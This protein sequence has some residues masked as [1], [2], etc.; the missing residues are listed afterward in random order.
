MAET[1]T[2]PRVV[3]AV[4]DY[5]PWRGG[6]TNLARN[7]ALGLRDRGWAVEI[8]TQRVDAHWPVLE[9]ID[10]V[11]VR[12]LPPSA[13]DGRSMRRY[14]FANLRSLRSARHAT[15]VVV[16]VM[17]PDLATGAV[18]AG[19][20]RRTVMVWAGAGD[21]HDALHRDHPS[22]AGRTVRVVRRAILRRAHHVALTRAID[23]EV[24]NVGVAGSTEVIPT[25]IDPERFRP[26]AEIE[27]RQRRVALGV[28]DAFVVVFSG[29]LRALKR[30]DQLVR[31]VPIVRDAHVPVRL[32]VLGEGRE[33]L[34]DTTGTLHALAHELGVAD[35]VTFTGAV[36][37]VE[38]YLAIADAFVLPSEREGLSNSLLEAMACGVACVA[39][40]SAGG[41]QILDDDCG[42][43]PPD[44][45]PEQLAAALVGLAADP[46][47][48]ARLAANARGRAGEAARDAVVDRYDRL[49]RG[50][51]GVSADR[52]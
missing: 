47:R 16:A 21:A 1:R 11:L 2:Q 35:A 24:R 13:R 9:R 42:V 32:F 34:V 18:V 40:A 50:L 25:P 36:D 49:L 37:E 3:V 27:R 44:N 38:D 33:D 12:R 45:S 29:H 28:D 15:D 23:D 31:A 7:L 41:D 43:I 46:I 20:R 19:F 51:D 26:L 48:R 22:L 5:L 52:S 10:D 6:T 39:P 8:L 17:T 14:L 30:V 4:A